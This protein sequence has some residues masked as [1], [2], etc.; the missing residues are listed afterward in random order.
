MKL[1]YCEEL[2]TYTV[3]ELKDLLD[4]QSI[5]IL[6]RIISEL[7]TKR[8]V[9]QKENGLF[10]F[11]FVGVLIFSEVILF[12]L[13]KYIQISDK[14]KVAKQLLL[15][16]HEYSKRENLEKEEVESLGEIDAATSYN[17]L[18]VIIFLLID[19]FESGLYKNE[20]N[21]YLFNGEDEIDWMK[22]LNEIQPIIIDGEPV[23]L[24]YYTTTTQNDEEN[25]FRQLHRY[26]LSE[27]S[28]KL[29]EL[30][31]EDLLGFE[32]VVFNIDEESLGSPETILSRINI[33]MNTQYNNRKQL[34]LK[35]M[36]SFISKERMENDNFSISFYGTRTFNLV[37][38]KTCAYILDNKYSKLKKYIAKPIW[39]TVSANT[40]ETRTLI[41]DIVS[42]LN[43]QTGKLMIISDAKYY[44]LLLSDS[45]ISGNPGVE[46]IAKQYL[47]QLALKD[48]ADSNNYYSILN[49]LLFPGEQE[50]LE[51][52]GSVSIGFLKKLEIDDIRLLKMPSHKV[53]D[54]YINS[55]KINLE[56]YL[57][58]EIEPIK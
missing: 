47:Y 37:W 32:P 7:E 43:N 35:A 51:N 11:E 46:D 16:F 44:N 55:K 50:E 23:C 3:N 17:M 36:S 33:E 29:T 9:I 19:Y 4:I 49:M 48:Y 39:R 40:H 5:T 45:R 14:R 15:L 41:P 10:F 22:T 56:K 13:P 53:F 1:V 20:K 57:N 54:M 34:L 2:K 30:G 24:E 6:G 26:I 38:E 8:I 21:V 25:Y 31:L 42:I 52:V 28:Q 18:S 12:S 27:S 58:Y